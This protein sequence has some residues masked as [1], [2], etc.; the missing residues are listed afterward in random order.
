M[1]QILGE[2]LSKNVM[3]YM[4]DILSY[5]K[6]K[7]DHLKTLREIFGRLRHFDLKLRVDKT[8]LFAKE[9]K[10][11]GHVI[12]EKGVRPDKTNVEAVKNFPTP[13]NL[14]RL[15]RFLGMASYFRKFIKNFAMITA[16]L[17][18]LCRKNIDFTW[19]EKENIAFETL[20]TILTT[21]PVLAFPDFSK[22]FY[23]SVDASDYAV[24]AYISNEK[25]SND[26]PI[27]YYSKALTA[28]QRNY[29][30]THKELL[31]IILAIEKF[32]HYIWGKHF[33][34]Y[35]DHQALTY[36][37]S[38]NKVGSRLLRWKILLAEYDFE[39]IHRKG[40][41]NVVSDC[42]SRVEEQ[43][44]EMQYFDRV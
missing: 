17:H 43:P 33:V 35:T 4:N 41:N 32:Q 11:L 3:A 8:V 21:A 30:T 29:S 28:P 5:N 14:K 1:T 40:K 2:M 26:R 37:F 36:L 18:T 22:T 7:E 12:N 20:K 42:L 13:K 6:T 27:E 44:K 15:Q 34:L 24:G 9:I 25:P 38:Q 39:I 31:A 23:I 19:T 10:Y 16:S